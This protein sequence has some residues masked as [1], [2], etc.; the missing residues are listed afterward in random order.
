MRLL[1]L[2]IVAIGVSAFAS[3]ARAGD[4][5]GVWLSD[6]GAS[7]VRFAPCGGA[8]CGHI[9]WLK[10]PDNS[11]AKMGERIFFDMKPDGDNAWSGS[12]FNPENGKTYSGKITLSGNTL[13]TKGCVLGGIIC[14]SVVWT[15]AN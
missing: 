2:A 7:K 6:T 10:D 3:A 9:A 13:T 4:V 14:R 11:P 15:R 12:A 8:L 1:N 5:A